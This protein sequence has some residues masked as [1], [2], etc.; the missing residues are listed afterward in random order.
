MPNIGSIRLTRLGPQHL[1]EL[2]AKKL[3]EGLSPTTVRHLHAVLHHALSQALRWGLLIRNVAQVVSPPRYRVPEFRSLTPDQARQFLENV[4]DDCLE[5]LYVLAL[6]SGMRQGELLALCWR[7]VD[8]EQ[9]AIHVRATLQRNGAVAEPKTRKGRRQIDLTPIAMDAFRRHRVRQ[10]QEEVTAG[11]TWMGLD[12]VFCNVVGGHLNPSNLRNRSF[13]PLLKRAGLPPMRFHDL[14]HS[15]A[16]LLL[17]L[18]T[19]PKVVQE[20]LGHSQIGITMDVYSHVLPTLQ[21]EA[22]ANLNRLLTA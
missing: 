20:L 7:D 13:A 16:T 15:A 11:P 5:A 9:G 10:W 12:L 14:R 21:Q 19:N 18:A 17:S 6:T 22:M 3:A 4:K 2:Y 1:Q 8:L